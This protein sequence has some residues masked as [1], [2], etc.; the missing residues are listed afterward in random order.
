M[1]HILINREWKG[2]KQPYA[3]ITLIHSGSLFEGEEN[4]L[5]LYSQAD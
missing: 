2:R 1:E 5:R 3:E 4:Y